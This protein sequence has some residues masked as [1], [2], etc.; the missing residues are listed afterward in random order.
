MLYHLTEFLPSRPKFYN[1]PYSSLFLFF[2]PSH[3][4]R[5]VLHWIV[6][7]RKLLIYYRALWLP[8]W[9]YFF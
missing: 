6:F 1:R 5:F 7:C 9:T 3:L 2:L 8:H 4:C